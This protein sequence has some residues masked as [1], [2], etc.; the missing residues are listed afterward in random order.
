MKLAFDSVN[1]GIADTFD[2][3]N[4]VHMEAVHTAAVERKACFATRK[5]KDIKNLLS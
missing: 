1:T 3:L 2:I 4:P 5:H